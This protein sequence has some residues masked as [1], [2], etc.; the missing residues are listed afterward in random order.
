MVLHSGYYTKTKDS[1]KL[2][3]N[4]IKENK[5]N[6]DLCFIYI[7]GLCSSHHLEQYHQ[8]K[9]GLKLRYIANVEIFCRNIRVA[10]TIIIGGI[11]PKVSAILRIVFDNEFLVPIYI[12]V[13]ILSCE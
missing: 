3:L 13:A 1:Q 11:A 12:V 9:G 8:D 2:F 5:R 6:L 10:K 4:Y 7:L